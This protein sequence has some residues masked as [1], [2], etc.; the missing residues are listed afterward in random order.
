MRRLGAAVL[1]GVASLSEP[2][3]CSGDAAWLVRSQVTAVEARNG[4]AAMQIEFEMDGGLAYMPGLAKPVTIEVDQLP[5]AE[6]REIRDQVAA[7][8]FF[9][10]PQQT[11]APP[12]RGADR[13][14]YIITITQGTER[15]QL[16]VTDPIQDE[17][18]GKLI[19]LIEVQARTARR[20]GAA[21]QSPKTG[22]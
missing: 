18:L 17:E 1:I 7:A 10:R 19:R 5:E 16:M 21:G 15:H 6:A 12:A 2:L 20:R 9:E 8:R 14:S 4:A 11:E 13:R 22:R 3:P